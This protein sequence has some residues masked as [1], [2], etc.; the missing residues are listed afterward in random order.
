M[1]ACAQPASLATYNHAISVAHYMPS[2]NLPAPGLCPIEWAPHIDV[3]LS[4]LGDFVADVDS[5]HTAF[6]TDAID[7][8]AWSVAVLW[9]AAGRARDLPA[10]HGMLG[11]AA[12]TTEV[13][14]AAALVPAFV[15]AMK[16]QIERRIAV[17]ADMLVRFC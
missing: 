13:A 14:Q 7:T 11:R 2:L 8:V 4:T 17:A 1:R 16:P 5:G 3:A 12:H 6:D 9:F 15:D 10:V